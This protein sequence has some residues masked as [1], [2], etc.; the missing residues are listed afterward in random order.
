MSLL[1]RILQTKCGDSILIK[2]GKAPVQNILVDSGYVDTYKT[3]LKPQMNEFDKPSEN[4]KLW[5]LTHLDADHINGSVAF[6][7]DKKFAPSRMPEEIWFNCFNRFNIIEKSSAKSV[8][9]GIEIRDFLKGTK[10]L[11]NNE[12]LAEKQ[13]EING[14]AI[15][16]IAPGK[17]QYDLLGEKWEKEEAAF[18]KKNSNKLKA[19]EES[20]YKF[21]I[22][23]L[24]KKADRKES[25][26]DINNLSSIA[27]ILIYDGKRILF[28]GDAT[29]T[30]IKQGLQEYLNKS[31]EQKI[32]CEYVKLPHH[33]SIY[34]YSESLFDLI[35][36]NQFIVCANGDNSHK[37]P[38]KE[39]LAKVLCHPK[40]NKDEKIN[41]IF[42]YSNT[43]LKSIFKVDKNGKKKYHFDCSF[44]KGSEK[45]Y[46]IKL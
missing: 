4:F 26:K 18:H 12:V 40:R 28:L 10:T 46:E 22:E 38:N 11:L 5:I 36:C 21:L 17:P 14:L 43:T 41:F 35:D 29:P 6:F 31:G 13:W 8:E 27:F 19:V 32:K 30:T 45:Y 9:K 34:N 7:R 33:G 44:P 20:D 39:T 42:N 25:K 3:A 15:E 23:E 37:L 2:L 24:V 1:I 16:V